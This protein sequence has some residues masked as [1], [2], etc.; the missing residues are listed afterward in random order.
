MW[1]KQTPGE[2]L[3]QEH[4]SQVDDLHGDLY[5][6][7]GRF[8]AL[9]GSAGSPQEREKLNLAQSDIYSALQHVT[10]IIDAR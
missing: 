10:E 5:S 7:Y 3:F 2:A 9:L 6:I 4:R 8:T 1:I